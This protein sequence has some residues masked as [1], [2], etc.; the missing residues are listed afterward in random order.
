[1]TSGL[2]FIRDSA[3][4]V[5]LAGRAR[6][7]KGESTIKVIRI[8]GQLRQIDI[9]TKSRLWIF[10]GAHYR[11]PFEELTGLELEA[12]VQEDEIDVSLIV[13]CE[14]EPQLTLCLQV[15]NL[16]RLEEAC[17]L[18]V[19][20]AAPLT[21]AREELDYRSAPTNWCGYRK[22]LEPQRLHL[23]LSRERASDVIVLTAPVEKAKYK[24]ERYPAKPLIKLGSDGS[25]AK[26]SQGLIAI[27]AI[28]L[29]F[30]PI[31]CASVWFQ[32][33]FL[34]LLGLIFFFLCLA[35]L[36]E[37]ADTYSGSHNETSLMFRF[38]SGLGSWATSFFLLGYAKNHEIGV[39]LGFV[40]TGWWGGLM[41]LAVL[42]G[43]FSPLQPA[44]YWKSYLRDAGVLALIGIT[45]ADYLIVGL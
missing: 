33:G 4:L 21:L 16:D 27:S 35:S 13:R 15:A 20:I 1:M 26:T 22:Y 3:K 44:K 40:L 32:S 30:T 37:S 14:K 6:R 38:S 45:I 41:L 8:D 17:D 5:C 39:G 7:R 24:E 18:F 12:R 36:Q 43:G 11:I 9:T 28:G 31:Y 2:V 29:F 25:A 10:P 42:S 23:Q 34:G 19:R